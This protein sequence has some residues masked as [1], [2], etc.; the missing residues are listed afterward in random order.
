MPLNLECVQAEL[1]SKYSE[2][3]LI[4]SREQNDIPAVTRQ[5]SKKDK[6]ENL[7]LSFRVCNIE[8]HIRGVHDFGHFMSQL[9]CQPCGL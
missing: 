2:F 4:F 3:K 7:S 1:K 5:R 6:V 9:S 8:S